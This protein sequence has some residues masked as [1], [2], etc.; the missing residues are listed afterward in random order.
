MTLHFLYNITPML[1]ICRTQRTLLPMIDQ[2]EDNE[3]GQDFEDFN[4]TSLDSWG[5][6][7]E[8]AE[9]TKSKG[10]SKDAQKQTGEAGGVHCPTCNKTFKSKY[11]LKVHNRYSI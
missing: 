1:F 9:E 10:Q 4:E 5:H 7:S 11:Y 2:D 8:T 3:D 6:D